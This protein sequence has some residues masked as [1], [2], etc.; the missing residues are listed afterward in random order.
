MG[1]VERPKQSEVKP[2]RRRL[3]FALLSLVLAVLVLASAPFVYISQA[4]GLSGLISKELSSRLSGVP[5]SVG[6]VGI[7]VR[8]PSFGVTL[9]ATG[10]EIDPDGQR[11]VLPRV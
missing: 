8:L 6:D 9:E 11:L 4:G 3:R 10:V 7:D 1:E 2:R 5:V